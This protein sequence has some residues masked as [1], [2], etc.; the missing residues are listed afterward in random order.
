MSS[1]KKK[2]NGFTGKLTPIDSETQRSGEKSTQRKK[3]NKKRHVFRST[4]YSIIN[5]TNQFKKI[6]RPV[7]QHNNTA[8]DFVNIDELRATNNTELSI[9]RH[10]NTSNFHSEMRNPNYIT[11]L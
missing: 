7:D 9:P 6:S 10:T 3:S 4:D 2:S 1:N 8:I 11:N 5:F